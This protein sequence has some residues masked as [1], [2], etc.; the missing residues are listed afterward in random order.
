MELDEGLINGV[1]M[2]A[3]SAAA[4]VALVALPQ[5]AAATGEFSLPTDRAHLC[6][7][8]PSMSCDAHSFCEY[9]RVGNCLVAAGPGPRRDTA[10]KPVCE[11]CPVRLSRAKGKLHKHGAGY[12]CTACFD[13][14]RRGTSSTITAL[15]VGTAQSRK[16]R[17][18]SDPGESPEPAASSALTRR[19]AAPKSAAT[20]GKQYN[21]RRDEHIMRLLDET[22]ARRLAAEATA[23]HH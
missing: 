2:D 17:A 14:Q 9:R 16:R 22:H 18:T 13:K 6:I 4:V 8:P 12:I 5:S 15:P 20:R 19:I 1:M 21:T 7:L 10:G 11:R 3:A 23:A